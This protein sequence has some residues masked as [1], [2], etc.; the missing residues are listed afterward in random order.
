MENTN[1]KK[2]EKNEI[3][4]VGYIKNKRKNIYV[5]TRMYIYM[6]TK[7]Y[8][9]RYNIFTTVYISEFNIWNI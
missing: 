1:P 6:N 5:C 2:V 7:T 9:S 4:R 3:D 8:L